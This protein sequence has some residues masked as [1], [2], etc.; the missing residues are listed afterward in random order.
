MALEVGRS[1]TCPAC[2]ELDAPKPEGRMNL[3]RDVLPLAEIAIDCKEIPG[4]KRKENGEMEKRKI[5]SIL[6]LGSH[7]FMAV[8][9]SKL[10][11]PTATELLQVYHER[12]ASIF[13]MPVKVHADPAGAH[14]S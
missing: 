7:F 13:G 1:F 2:G 5:L 9:L 10:T 3:P 14:V 4:W 8:L 12:W 6:D 11:D